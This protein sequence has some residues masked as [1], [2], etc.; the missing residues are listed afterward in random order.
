M[1]SP[2]PAGKAPAGAAR[3]AG[4][5]SGKDVRLAAE[6]WESLFRSQVAVMRRLQSGPA[7]KKLPVKEYD[8]LF[9]LSRCPT[10][11][12]R[13]N[14]INDHVLLSQSSLSRLVDRLEKRGLVERSIAP[15]DGRGILLG[16]TEAGVALQKEIG[17]E[18]VRD[19]AELLLPALSA[20][21][22]QELMRL[23]EKLRSGLPD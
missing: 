14:E 23:T 1:S 2:A 16:L 13:L 5:A 19:I 20:T 11:K 22:Q 7:F 10:G 17:R 12:L 21:E 3:P 9:T 15:E 6:A 4:A 8:V 18:H